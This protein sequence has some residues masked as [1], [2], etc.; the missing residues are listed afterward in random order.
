MLIVLCVLAVVNLIGLGVLF[1]KSNQSHDFSF[2]S[3]EI[4]PLSDK[5]VQLE[6]IIQ[7]RFENQKEVTRLQVS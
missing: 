1:L 2:L 4:K 7:Q 5:L 6:V 3:Q